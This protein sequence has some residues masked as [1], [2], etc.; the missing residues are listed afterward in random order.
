[1]IDS[2]DEYHGERLDAIGGDMKLDECFQ[3]GVCSLAC[4]KGLDPRRA[5]EQLKEMYSEHQEEKEKRE[6]SINV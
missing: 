5:L 4:P 6:L 1:V 2:R 3:L